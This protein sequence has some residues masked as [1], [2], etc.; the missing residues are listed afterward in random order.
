MIEREDLSLVD[1]PL[2]EAS[3]IDLKC[4]DSRLSVEAERLTPIE[5]LKEV[6]IG[7][8]GHQLTNISTSLFQEEEHE[9]VDLLIKNIKFFAWAPSD[10]PRID[11]KVVSHRLTIYL[12]AKPVVKR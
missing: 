12:F 7:P 10:M 11:T 3:N 6:H 4:W 5:D 9:L 1:A 2:S 8:F